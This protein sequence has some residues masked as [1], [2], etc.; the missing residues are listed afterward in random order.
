MQVIV[1]CRDRR[2]GEQSAP[3]YNISLSSAGTGRPE[4]RVQTHSH[5]TLK[6]PYWYLAPEP[7]SVLSGHTVNFT[8]TV[9][10]L[11]RLSLHEVYQV[12]GATLLI[13]RRR[14]GTLCVTI[15]FGLLRD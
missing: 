6:L 8:T 12:G 14:V 2:D 4:A 11:W 1:H 7:L 13:Y 10:L 5:L 15:G 3:L 9:S